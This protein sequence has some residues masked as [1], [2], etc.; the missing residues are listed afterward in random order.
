MRIEQPEFLGETPESKAETRR[1]RLR[2]PHWRA[3]PPGAR[4][5]ELAERNPEAAV[6]AAR[7]NA[8]LIASEL[9]DLGITVDCAPVADVPVPVPSFHNPPT[10]VPRYRVVT[11]PPAF[12]AL[13]RN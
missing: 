5:G 10:P 9:A 2:P 6:R 11:V 1:Q 12:I 13:T 3:A 4:F 8:R 7:L